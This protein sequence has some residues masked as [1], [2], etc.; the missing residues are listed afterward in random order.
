M[1]LR[2]DEVVDLAFAHEVQS[3]RSDDLLEAIDAFRQRRSGSY[4][5][6]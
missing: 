3:V 4:V 2:A 5:G 6:R 1:R